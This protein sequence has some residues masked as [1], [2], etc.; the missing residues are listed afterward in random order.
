M[1]K[2]NLFL[3]YLKIFGFI[4]TT[5]ILL[6]SK[7]ANAKSKITAVNGNQF[8]WTNEQLDSTFV[9]DPVT[10]D[11]FIYI[12]EQKPFIYKVNQDSTYFANQL[13]IQA[14]FVKSQSFESYFQDAVLKIFHLFPTAISSINVQNVIVS[15]DGK[16]I[17]QDFFFNTNDTMFDFA[18]FRLT[19]ANEV[20]SML[21][22]LRNIMKNAPLFI[23]GMKD[24]IAVNSI[25]NPL[26]N[27]VIK[28][29]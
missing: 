15:P 3:I 20:Q 6:F 22:E 12:T 1:K 5:A 7:N 9:L 11:E 4:L 24:N 19:H 17:Y 27:L 23:P 8:Y 13:D 28:R 26:P 10:G 21:F 29:W 16:I 25:L 2:N 14:Q 18:Q